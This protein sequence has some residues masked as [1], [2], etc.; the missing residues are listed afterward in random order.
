MK[1]EMRSRGDPY[2]TRRGEKNENKMRPGWPPKGRVSEG[3]RSLVLRM[4][5][6]IPRGAGGA[7]KIGVLSFRSGRAGR[8]EGGNGSPFGSRATGQRPP[9]EPPAGVLRTEHAAVVNQSVQL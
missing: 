4:A 2:E 3:W 7:D 1:P 9:R 6:Q 8:E 5:S